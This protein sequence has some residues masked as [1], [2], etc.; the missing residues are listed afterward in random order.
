MIIS[1]IKLGIS[2]VVLSAVLSATQVANAFDISVSG[3]IRQEMAYKYTGEENQL[4]RYG[5]KFNGTTPLISGPLAGLPPGVTIGGV[6][7]A[8]RSED[9]DWNLFGTKAEVDIS[10]NF[11]SELSAFVKLR[12]YYMWD[13][14]DST[15][16]S[17]SADG[18]SGKVNH[19]NVNNHGKEPTY[20]SLTNNDYMLDVPAM[21]LDWTKGKYWVRIGQQQI[22]WGEALFFRVQDVANGLDLRRHVFFDL[23][24]EEYADER[25]SSPGIRASMAINP[26]WELEVFAQMFQPSLLPT[27]NSPFNVIANGFNPN[28]E[29]GY[30]NTQD[31]INAG[32]RLSGQFDQ[33][34]VQVFAVARHD[35]NPI[36]DLLPSGQTSAGGLFGPGFDTQPFVYQDGGYGASSAAE[37]FYLSQ[38]QGVDGVAVLNNLID[39]YP[40]VNAIVTAGFGMTQDPNGEWLNTIDGGN[41][42]GLNTLGGGDPDGIDANDFLGAFFA[43]PLAPGFPSTGGIPNSTLTGQIN[44]HYASENVFGFGL[45]YIFYAEQDTLLDQM[46]VRFEASMTPDK[47]FSNNLS[48]QFIEA[49]EY[50]IS[51][52]IEKYHRF[53]DSFPATFFIFEWMHRSESDLLGRHLSGIG[54]D[55][56][57]RP[58]GGEQDRG[59]NGLVF[60]FQQPSPSL[61]WRFDLSMLWDDQGGIFVQPSVRYKPNNDWIVETFVNIVDGNQDSVFQPFDYM[62][63]I[64]V[65]L[66]YQF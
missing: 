24:A 35:P 33:L 5:S 10:M 21:Y 34:G 45:N 32:V 17:G 50:L 25:M 30:D 43:A 55:A 41:I 22:A 31:N 23:G 18:E 48:S 63:D 14:F 19:F 40:F 54:G 66:T 26:T 56:D 61:L 9:N 2:A 15:P 27:N 58:G 51:M 64:T 62:D 36:F 37:W 3:F 53:S 20:L 16:D 49:D 29:E 42:F 4:N 65:R 38:V 8:D 13:V 60:A 1:K 46:V 59:W 12:G 7:K 44:A 11:N 6:P 47:K 39:D 52:V 28:Y 57:S